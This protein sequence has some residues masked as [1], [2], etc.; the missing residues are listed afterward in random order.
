VVTLSEGAQGSD[1]TKLQKQLKVLGFNP[2]AA[3][4]DFG[5]AT[6]AA[7]MAFQKSEGL[8]ADGI[9]GP[10]T[11]TALGL[12]KDDTLPTAIPSVTPVIVSKMFPS[13]PVDNIKANLP[14]V[15]D[16]LVDQGLADKPMV[17]MALASIRAETEGFEPISEGRSKF[18]TSPGGH[19]FDLYD[20]RRD[21]GNQGQGDGDRFK[22]RGFIQ[23]T[24]RAN[25]QKYSKALGMGN[26]LVNKPELANEPEIAAALLASFLKDKERAVKEALLA[27]D[28]R[29]ARRLVN[30]GS[31]GLDRFSDTYEK[32]N[33]LIA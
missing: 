8:L 26:Q 7:L 15:L 24:G 6:T 9:A 1:V 29:L 32:G 5:P 30:G 12:G 10:R 18:N 2:G 23:L 28:L 25:Y 19:P 4:G 16:A 20:N 3:D 31:H 13:T 33:A 21:L 27:H 22:G 14:F 17:L 11:L